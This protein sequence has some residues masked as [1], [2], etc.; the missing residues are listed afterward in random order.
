MNSLDIAEDKMPSMSK[1]VVPN[2]DKL[3]VDETE[4]SSE[5]DS[6]AEGG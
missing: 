2:C 3:D 4:A 1:P 5:E 6:S